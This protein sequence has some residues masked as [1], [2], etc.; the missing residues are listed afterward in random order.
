MQLGQNHKHI[1]SAKWRSN[2]KWRRKGK[3]TRTD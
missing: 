2:E 3:I 1:N